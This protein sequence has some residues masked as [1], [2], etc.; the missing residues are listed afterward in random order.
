MQPAQ[1][2]QQS[3]KAVKVD[4]GTTANNKQND[5]KKSEALPQTGD[6]KDQSMSIWGAVLVALSGLMGIVYKKKRDRN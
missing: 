4:G 3:Y 1:P 6:E 5:S 2:T